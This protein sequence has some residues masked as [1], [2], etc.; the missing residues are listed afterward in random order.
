LTLVVLLVLSGAGCSKDQ[1][2][3]NAAAEN[4]GAANLPLTAADLERFLAVVQNHSEGMIPEFTPPDESESLDLNASAEQLVESFRGEV[5]RLF[6]ATRQGAIW[7]RDKQW[8][9]ALAGQKISA[10]QFAALVRKVSL[11]IMRVRLDAR[12]DVDQ[13]VVQARRQVEKSMRLLDEFDAVPADDRTRESNDVR[14]ETAERLGK[15]VALL[16]FAEMVK[17]VP[18]ESKAVVRKYSSKLKALLPPHANDELLAELK[19]L[20]TPRG[21]TAKQAGYEVPNE[22]DER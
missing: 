1:S 15:A 12:V 21:K 22:G 8:S 9:Q 5:R 17:E 19:E 7:E 2:F 13:L 18:P 16:E 6:D 14:A 10:E 11:A 20:A 4:P 3:E